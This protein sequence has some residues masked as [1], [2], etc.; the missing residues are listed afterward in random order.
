MNVILKYNPIQQKVVYRFRKKEDNV[1]MNSHTTNELETVFSLTYEKERDGLNGFFYQLDEY[2]QD[3]RD[4]LYGWAEDLKII[5]QKLHIGVSEEGY[6]VKIFNQDEI[7]TIWKKQKAHIAGKH[8]MEKHTDGMLNDIEHLLTNEEAF[9]E[10]LCYAPPFSLLFSGLHGVVFDKEKMIGRQKRMYGVA[11][12]PYIPLV[13]E[14]K[15]SLPD[16]A[17]GHCE[18][19][20]FGNLDTENLNED[21]LRSFVRL[22]SD[23]PA[24]SS[25]L[26][27]LHIETYHFDKQNW[28]TS[29]KTTH[30]SVINGFMKHTESCTLQ[31][32][33]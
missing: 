14:D 25:D 24:A 8:K 2:K 20:S 26:T 29:A 9:V 18:I 4:G 17:D 7:H 19:S 15:I 33:L 12:I 22:L 11:G 30:I 27:L 10:T 1:L 32:I 3:Q 13:M 31:A 21:K 23:N 5:T 16:D 6:L 28:I